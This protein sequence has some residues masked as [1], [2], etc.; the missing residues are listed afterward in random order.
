MTFA[1][2]RERFIF[3][4]VIVRFKMS[5][6]TQT[7]I[8]IFVV[9]ASGGGRQE[10]RISPELTVADFKRELHSINEV[11]VEDQRLI[12][13]GRILKDEDTLSSYGKLSLLPF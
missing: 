5:S 7:T 6:E 11:A 8:R 10:V 12:Y 13:R 3:V 4:F 2:K 9:S 1:F